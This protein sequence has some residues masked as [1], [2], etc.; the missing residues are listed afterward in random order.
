M[1]SKKILYYFFRFIT[2]YCALAIIALSGCTKKGPDSSTALRVALS[3][4]PATLDPRKATDATG[5]RLCNLLFQ[6][7]VR[8][9]SDLNVVGDAASDWSYKDK[10]YTFQLKSGL[11][12]HNGRPLT[13]EDL[14]FS[15]EEF[16]SSLSPFSSAFAPIQSVEV[17]E[18]DGGFVVQVKVDQ[19]SAKFLS[20]D[21]PVLKLLPKKETL[22]MKD[23]FGDRPIGS[24]PL[25][26]ESVEVQNIRLKR[27]EKLPEGSKLF[28]NFVF[29][30]IKDDFTRSQKLLKGE[31]DLAIAELPPDMVKRLEKEHS[32][33]LK[34]YTY[35]GLSMTYILL[36]LKDKILS[37]QKVRKAI[38]QAIDRDQVIE[39][40]LQGLGQA[41]TSLLTPNNPFFNKD[42]VN[43]KHSPEEAGK[44]LKTLGTLSFKTSSNPMAVD[45]GKVLAN[46][47]EKSG[48]KVNLQ[49]FEWGT[50]YND[51]K[52]GNFQ[53]ATMKWVGAFDPDIYRIAFHSDELPPGRNRS[54][55]QNKKL[56]SLLESAFRIEDLERR[57]RAYLEI[58]RIIFEDDVI[59][60]LWYE[61]QAAILDK[62]LDGFEPSA[63][64]DYFG[65]LKISKTVASEGK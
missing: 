51:V 42:L 30:V 50:F 62:N 17:V 37:D 7:L 13:K 4:A 14:L 40:K 43:A 19:Y 1:I 6:S 24:G 58:Q 38:G 57:K 25:K 27:V 47:L 49:S 8:V 22:E 63:L 20:S 60:P 29:K 61:T 5:M 10:V 11:Q 52:T 48:L 36:N 21:L 41:A 45:H 35:P 46:Q 34:V 32:D 39:Y 28:E 23:N 56:D 53:M 31:L 59:I 44:V 26:I 15:F 65:I 3:S 64:S 12:F 33:Q 54:H 2:I 55:Y 16:K 9:D 18:K